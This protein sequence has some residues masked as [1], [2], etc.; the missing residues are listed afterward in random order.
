MDSEE[1]QAL[2]AQYEA[3]DIEEAE[4]VAEEIEEVE[5]AEVSANQEE[6]V[7][8]IAEEPEEVDSP[9]GYIDS[10]EDWIAAG[11][12]PDRFRGKKAYEAEYERIQEVKELKNS[13]KTMQDT[14]KSTVEAV[15]R[16]EEQTNE[17]HRQELESV[18]ANARE[19]GDTDAAL[20]AAGKLHAIDSAPKRPQENPVIG[21]FLTG[22]PVLES[23]EIK[24]EF[25]RIYNGKLKAD[26]VGADEQLSDAAMR[27]YLKASMDSVKAIY[28]DRFVSPKIN[29][30]TAPK[31]K[32]KP[33]AK[34]VDVVSALKSYK[35]D[36]AS[37]TNSGAPLGIYNML[38]RDVSELA[39]KNY[40][41]TVLGVKL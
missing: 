19:E 30:Q 4:I 32:A 38:K 34:S 13:F 5:E 1:L 16:R 41:E 27:G 24:G 33:V 22:N 25:A 10:M 20:D 9:P 37:A 39:A 12:D 29:R 8:E 28:P 21:D 18:L 2:A 6:E 35:V 23:P 14:L 31:L 3:E 11:K 26:G 15:A 7:A 17:Q 40:A 36:G